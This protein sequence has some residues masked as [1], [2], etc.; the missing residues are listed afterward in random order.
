M[1]TSPD[2]L[3]NEIPEQH[4]IECNLRNLQRCYEQHV[5]RNMRFSSSYFHHT[6]W[7]WNLLDKSVQDSPSLAELKSKFLRI[8]RPAQN[9]VYNIYDILGIKLLTRP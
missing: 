2:Y 8:I 1:I 7:E 6:I 3:F 5:G 4:L 9:P